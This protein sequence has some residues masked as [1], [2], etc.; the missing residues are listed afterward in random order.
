MAITRREA[1]K[2]I[3]KGTLPVL[4]VGC[5]SAVMPQVAHAEETVEVVFIEILQEDGFG[6]GP[7]GRPE[8]WSRPPPPT[9][10]RV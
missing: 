1:F 10:S 7:T 5:A 6:P 8:C 2:N 9:A 3:A 4:A